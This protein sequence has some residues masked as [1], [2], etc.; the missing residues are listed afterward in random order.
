MINNG[1]VL[2][3]QLRVQKPAPQLQDIGGTP[4][5]SL[6]SA[7]VIKTK[8]NVQRILLTKSTRSTRLV[9]TAT[10]IIYIIALSYKGPF[11]S[12]K[13]LVTTSE[14]QKGTVK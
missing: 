5:R 6:T 2:Q 4:Y 8:Q 9:Y 1:Q 14:V 3:S 11:I 12:L 13:Q 10:F 7:T